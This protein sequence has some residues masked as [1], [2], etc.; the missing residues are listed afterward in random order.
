MTETIPTGMGNRPYMGAKEKLWTNVHYK[1]MS[2]NNAI[3]C[4]SSF[5]NDCPNRHK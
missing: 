1:I 2:F 3:F 5:I 4:L